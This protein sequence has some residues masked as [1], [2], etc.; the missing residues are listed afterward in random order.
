[1]AELAYDL[2][3]QTRI[4]AEFCVK[5]GHRYRISAHCRDRLGG[6]YIVS[7]LGQPDQVIAE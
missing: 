3:V 7:F 1:M 4:F 5:G 2:K 6:V